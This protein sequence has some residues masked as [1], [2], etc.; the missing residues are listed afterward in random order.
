M[1]AFIKLSGLKSFLSTTLRLI[2]DK[3]RLI[4]L[5]MFH[6]IFFEEVLIEKKKV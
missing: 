4:K 3:A 2:T 5:Q 1:L 6:F